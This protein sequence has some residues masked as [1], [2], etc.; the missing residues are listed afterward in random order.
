VINI[1][2][3]NNGKAFSLLNRILNS[4]TDLLKD[5]HCR[6]QG[7]KAGLMTP[8]NALNPT[9]KQWIEVLLS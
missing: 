4:E 3:R 2:K 9:Q 8:K 5:C 7:L 1:M 6:D